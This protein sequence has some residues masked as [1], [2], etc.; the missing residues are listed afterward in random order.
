MKL[1]WRHKSIY[2]YLR[3]VHV[4]VYLW[5]F[6]SLCLRSYHPCFWYCDHQRSTGC[7]N[8]LGLHLINASLPSFRMGRNCEVLSL[9]AYHV[10]MCVCVCRKSILEDPGT[11]IVKGVTFGYSM[12]DTRR[13]A[14]RLICWPISLLPTVFWDSGFYLIACLPNIMNQA[15]PQL[16]I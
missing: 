11:I 2:R 13:I 9:D 7:C 14:R 1:E 15:A 4:L 12:K 5:F 8:P 6:M 3:C 16:V 10:C